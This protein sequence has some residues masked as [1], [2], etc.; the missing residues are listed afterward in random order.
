MVICQ[1]AAGIEKEKLENK[2]GWIFC[3]L[4]TRKYAVA[5]DLIVSPFIYG[6]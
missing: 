3:I 5:V 2:I 4:K 6:F 1:I